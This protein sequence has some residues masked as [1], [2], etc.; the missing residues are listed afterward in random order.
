MSASKPA[1]VGH[2]GS[3]DNVPLL[4]CAPKVAGDGETWHEVEEYGLAVLVLWS[5]RLERA[6]SSPHDTPPTTRVTREDAGRRETWERDRTAEEQTAVDDDLDELL[7]EAGVPPR[8]RGRRWFV[9]LPEHVSLEDAVRTWWQQINQ[10]LAGKD[11]TPAEELRVVSE[12][13]AREGL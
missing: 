7:A 13:L 12:I 8:P 2:D 4:D 3:W 9:R 11:Q 10:Q 6:A 1:P 5:L